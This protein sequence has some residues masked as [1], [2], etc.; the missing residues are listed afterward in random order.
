MIL[1]ILVIGCVYAFMKCQ[2]NNE[3]IVKTAPNIETTVE[4]NVQKQG[5][6]QDVNNEQQNYNTSQDS[7]EKYMMSLK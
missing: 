4:E 5:A 7:Q 6:E 3:A 1:A 2:E